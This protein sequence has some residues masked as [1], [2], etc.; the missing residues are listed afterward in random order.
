MG[1]GDFFRKLTGG[2]SGSGGTDP[3]G[4][5]VEY[6]GFTIRPAPKAQGGGQF[7]TAGIISKKFGDGDEVKEHHF[8]RADTHTSRDSAS[9]HAI[10]KGKQIIDEQ[11]DRVFQ[12]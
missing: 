6:Q 8:I 1:L 2:G 5:P 9:D 7:L 4:D 10:S 12:D 11:G 3:V